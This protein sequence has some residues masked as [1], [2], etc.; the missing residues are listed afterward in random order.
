MALS[1]GV[2]TEEE[3]TH[4]KQIT[5]HLGTALR[6]LMMQYFP[7]VIRDHLQ[8]AF[9]T[10][11]ADARITDGEW[12]AV[13]ATAARLDVG[14]A[15]LLNV[16]RPQS[17]HHIEQVLAE[18]RADEVL[19]VEED[20]LI[21]LLL[22]LFQA[23]GPFRNYIEPQLKHYERLRE[24][25]AGQL[26]ILRDVPMELRAGEMV[27]FQ[28]NAV[29]ARPRRRQGQ[30][31]YEPCPGQ[32]TITDARMVFSSSLVTTAVNH[33]KV[34]KILARPAGR[35]G[36][37]AGF[38]LFANGKGGGH[39]GLSEDEEMG[40]AIYRVA[41]AKVNQLI[42]NHTDDTRRIAREVRQRV[43]QRDGGR[44]VECGATQ[45]LEFDHVIPVARGGDNSEANV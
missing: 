9:R 27:H 10:A 44:C 39:Y 28:S 7:T 30:I 34:V 14:E 33:R 45:Y 3:A 37:P 19:S 5:A 43:W 1:D 11:A 23:T 38:E 40:I 41:V 31:E 25:A 12:A 8:S 2:L 6:P 16:I 4:L 13:V 17:E 21:R 18:A 24:I 32:I 42:V 15:E 35:Q 26:P 36:W 22:D 20:S 29:F